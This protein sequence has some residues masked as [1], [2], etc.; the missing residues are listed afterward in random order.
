MHGGTVVGTTKLPAEH[1][2]A[3]LSRLDKV[4]DTLINGKFQDPTADKLYSKT[5]EYSMVSPAYTVQR[6]SYEMHPAQDLIQVTDLNQKKSVT[7][8]QM[9]SESDG[10][11]IR[12]FC[13]MSQGVVDPVLKEK[14]GLKD[15]SHDT[16]VHFEY[17]GLESEGA[18]TYRRF[19][20]IPS[21][22]FSAWMGSEGAGKIPNT[23]YHYWDDADSDSFTPFRLVTPGGDVVV[24]TE[25]SQIATDEEAEVFLKNTVNSTKFGIFAKPYK[26]DCD[27]TEKGPSNADFGTVPEMN[28]GELSSGG[29]HF[30]ARYLFDASTDAELL[31]GW[32]TGDAASVSQ[33]VRH[34]DDLEL[35]MSP[36]YTYLETVTKKSRNYG[37][38]QHALLAHGK[39]S[40]AS[41][42][43]A[44]CA[45]ERNAVQ[46]HM[47]EN[48]NGAMCSAP[49]LQPLVKC[50]ESLDSQIYVYCLQSIFWLNYETTCFLPEQ[51]TPQNRRL[52]AGQAEVQKL[53]DGTH[54]L[55]L[56]SL[57][58]QTKMYLSGGISASQQ[59][60]SLGDL[61]GYVLLYNASNM[62]EPTGNA[63]LSTWESETSADSSARSLVSRR[64]IGAKACPKTYG[65]QMSFCIT[66]AFPKPGFMGAKCM[67]AC[68]LNNIYP[69]PAKRCSLG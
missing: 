69:M 54:S 46:V 6:T 65:N 40:M 11:A 43:S 41:V 23:V 3:T 67:K 24:Y 12:N 28:G 62:E 44:P 53:P 25:V 10:S 15:G 45:A 26:M 35:L 17:V 63:L 59:D 8:Q 68:A 20:M 14:E 56:G 5:S 33:A 47:A 38:V 19:R 32:Y 29:I 2:S 37:F 13:K 57:D 55:D 1:A 16:S 58:Q 30:Y 66:F 31:D 21:K 22:D 34:G 50:L 49:S 39:L 61:N 60:A 64:L 7:F 27:E 51:K 9:H 52:Q 18:K 4:Q 36:V 48:A 42:C